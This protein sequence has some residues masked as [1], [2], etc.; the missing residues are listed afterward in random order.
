M[1]LLSLDYRSTEVPVSKIYPP[2]RIGNTKMRPVFDWWRMIKP[3]L[4]L[5]LS[6]RH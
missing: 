4:L 1:K 6:L 2:R 5:G 3:I